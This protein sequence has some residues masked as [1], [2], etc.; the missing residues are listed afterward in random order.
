MRGSPATMLMALFNVKCV[1]PVILFFRNKFNLFPGSLP[2]LSRLLYFEPFEFAASINGQR[3]GPGQ[4]SEQNRKMC[5]NI[6]CD[7]NRNDLSHFV[8]VRAWIVCR[9]H[10]V[11][12]LEPSAGLPEAQDWLEPP[13]TCR[14]HK[15]RDFFCHF[16][17]FNWLIERNAA[18]C[19]PK[20]THSFVKE[21]WAAKDVGKELTCKSS[22]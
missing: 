21:L 18:A 1:R 4:Y 22:G 12:T 11:P 6:N 17:R 15:A 10:N 2:L 16:F 8:C 19:L 3:P 7:Q 9:I 13:F 5:R 14:T 20:V